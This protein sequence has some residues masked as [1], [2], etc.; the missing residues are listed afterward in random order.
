MKGCPIFK[1]APQKTKPSTVAE[2]FVTRIGYDDFNVDVCNV[3]LFH[4]GL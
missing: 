1:E 2:G 3:T 4:T